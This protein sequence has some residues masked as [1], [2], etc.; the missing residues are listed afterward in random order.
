[1]Q[2]DLQGAGR[3]IVENLLRQVRDQ[4]TQPTRL[5]FRLVVRSSTAAPRPE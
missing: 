2:V 1:V 4:R 3:Q 5:D